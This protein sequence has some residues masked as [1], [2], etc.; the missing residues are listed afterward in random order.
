[1]KEHK[2]IEEFY[3]QLIID[4]DHVTL[5]LNQLREYAYDAMR[6]WDEFDNL[7]FTITEVNPK[8]INGTAMQKPY[9]RVQYSFTN[10]GKK[11]RIST[12]IGNVTD[13]PLGKNDPKLIE[14]A[15]KKLR[16]LMIE[17]SILPSR[18]E[19]LESS[20][21]KFINSSFPIYHIVKRYTRRDEE[22]IRPEKKVVID[23]SRG[24]LDLFDEK[25]E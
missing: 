5:K 6:F 20:K 21:D 8:I 7:K 16:E 14:I 18:Y 10:N 2:T 22:L 3:R 11:E 23:I 19:V 17:K 12:Y 1:M 9:F 13:F 25:S 24:D 4:I 15:S